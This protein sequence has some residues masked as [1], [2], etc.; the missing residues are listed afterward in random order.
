MTIYLNI[1]ISLKKDKVTIMSCSIA[2]LNQLQRL[3]G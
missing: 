3:L 2:R 1:I